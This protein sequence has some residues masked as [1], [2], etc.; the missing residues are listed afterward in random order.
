MLGHHVARPAQ[1]RGA[2]GPIQMSWIP[3]SRSRAVTAA[4]P[5]TR[6]QDVGGGVVAQDE[7]QLE[8]VV[9]RE[10]RARADRSAMTPPVLT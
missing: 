6:R 4:P 1:R 8:Q 7:H 3:I 2:H 5:P 9:D 10:R